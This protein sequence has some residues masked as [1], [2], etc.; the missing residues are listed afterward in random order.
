MIK[1]AQIKIALNLG[2]IAAVCAALIG[3]VM[4]LTKESIAENKIKA[5]QALIVEMMSNQGFSSHTLPPT[6]GFEAYIQESQEYY[7]SHN[8][9]RIVLPWKAPNA[10]QEDIELF[11]AINKSGVIESVRVSNHKETPGL[12]DKIELS[13]SNWILSFNGK[14]KTDEKDFQ[15]KKYGGQFDSFSGATITPQAVV[16]SVY[17]ALVYVETLQHLLFTPNDIN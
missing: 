12:G 7:I 17:Q 15:V 4:S 5:R 6:S 2:L 14:Q 10:Y 9:Q 11:I 8:N 16:E 1:P 3:M 13:K